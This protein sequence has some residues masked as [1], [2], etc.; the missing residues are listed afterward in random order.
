[1]GPSMRLNLLHPG[2]L[3]ANLLT[4]E[5]SLLPEPVHFGLLSKLG[6]Q[7]IRGPT[8]GQCQGGP[9]E[10]NDLN[11]RRADPTGPAVGKR[12]RARRQ[13]RT[14]GG[15]PRECKNEGTGGSLAY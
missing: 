3:D 15:L 12:E 9:C 4:K 7:A 2:I 8:V 14:H 1:M 5:L 10:G 13:G 6:V 11:D